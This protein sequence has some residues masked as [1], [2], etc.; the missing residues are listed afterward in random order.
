MT[1]HSISIPPIRVD[2]PIGDKADLAEVSGIIRDFQQIT[3]AA[4]ANLTAEGC[5]RS[6][7]LFVN[8]G[9][10]RGAARLFRQG[11]QLAPNDINLCLASSKVERRE[12]NVELALDL[13]IRAAGFLEQTQRLNAARRAISEFSNSQEMPEFQ[14][15]RAVAYLASIEIRQNQAEKAASMLAEARERVPR[16]PLLL[17]AIGQVSRI[18]GEYRAAEGILDEAIEEAKKLRNPDLLSRIMAAKATL[19]EQSGD[20]AA[21]RE[22]FTKALEIARSPE[23][24]AGFAYFLAVIDAEPQQAETLAREAADKASA[25]PEIARVYHEIPRLTRLATELQTNWEA[26]RQAYSKGVTLNTQRCLEA[27]RLLLKPQGCIIADTV[28]KSDDDNNL[29]VTELDVSRVFGFLDIP[30]HLDLIIMIKKW[31]QD[32]RDG[33]F[34]ELLKNIRVY[35]VVLVLDTQV[36]G[37]LAETLIRLR[38]NHKQV[39]IL[40]YPDI[41]RLIFSASD[42]IL[43]RQLLVQYQIDLI[44]PY[45]K[46]GAVQNPHMFFGR[47]QEKEWI[48]GKIPRA[49]IILVGGRRIGKTTLLNHLLQFELAE[50]KFKPLLYDCTVGD[51]L[52]DV[53]LNMTKR[54]LPSDIIPSEMPRTFGE[55]F[56][57]IHSTGKATPVIMLDEADKLVAIDGKS[58][59][60]FLRAARAC[61]QRNECHFV[62]CGERA[63]LEATQRS[64]SPLFNFGE[65]YPLGFLDKHAVG[66]L[67]TQPMK[68]LGIDLIEPAKIGDSVLDCT[69]GHPAIVQWVCDTAV[70]NLAGANMRVLR[71]ADIQ[72]ITNQQEFI[73]YFLSTSLES[74]TVL[75][76][77][78]AYM[79]ARDR[80]LRSEKDVYDALAARHLGVPR[81]EVSAA[82]RRLVSLRRILRS[83]GQ[84]Y[85]IAMPAFVSVAERIE[86]LDFRIEELMETYDHKGDIIPKLEE[87][88][89]LAIFY[90]WLRKARCL[91]L[92]LRKRGQV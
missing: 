43:K 78:C 82:L 91:F 51:S 57:L 13:A 41:R 89:N 12:G 85:E 55:L 67:V 48:C 49:N 32:D 33:L 9:D 34:A 2:E 31:A 3:E 63:L 52:A 25:D 36:D 40:T 80:T 4:P 38:N 8:F 73:D 92:S 6:G 5:L 24:L 37:L 65:V 26:L 42:W 84:N 88:K 64:D 69:S 59:F 27:A 83:S 90:R 76:Q 20:Y 15:G 72:A 45:H 28:L 10:M 11:L 30:T 62:L 19:L 81:R 7:L 56:Q 47:A 18:R 61:S 17:E 60:A 29:L 86:N 75:E 35:G 50:L 1:T 22:S 46:S 23:A 70:K 66:E 53:L 14:R 58:G 77:L 44:S 16:H 71:D 79:I 21:A 74:A 54:W 68:Q 87:T 39:A